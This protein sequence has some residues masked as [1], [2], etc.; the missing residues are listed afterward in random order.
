MSKLIWTPEALADVQRLYRFLAPKDANAAQR[1]V[2]AIRAGVKML[3]QHPRVGR[4]VEDM[5]PEFR[6]WPIGFGNSGYVALYHFDG[7]TAVILAVRHQKEA[8][9]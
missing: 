9:Y 7:K 1:A 4:P 2:Q 5:E 8:G 6:E 3:A